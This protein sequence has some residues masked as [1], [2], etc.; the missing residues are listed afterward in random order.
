MV[1]VREHHLTNGWNGPCSWLKTEITSAGSL[2]TI[3]I[4]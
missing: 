1:I 3:T 4:K 2:I